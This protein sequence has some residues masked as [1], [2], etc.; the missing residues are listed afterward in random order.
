MTRGNQRD[1]DRARALKQKAKNGGNN[2]KKDKSDVPYTTKMEN[3]AD[4]MRE[5][6]RR[7]DEKK[8]QNAN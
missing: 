3:N 7:A 2:K 5:K 1:L 4:I 6:Q 8:A